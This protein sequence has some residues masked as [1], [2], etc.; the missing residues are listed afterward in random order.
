[1]NIEMDLDRFIRRLRTRLVAGAKTYGDQ[2]F[3][4]PAAELVTEVM[5]ELEDVAGWSLLLWIRLDR[6]RERV[7][8]IGR[9]A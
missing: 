3:Q 7:E 5:E 2:S 6:L 8:S 9:E 4:R 1:M